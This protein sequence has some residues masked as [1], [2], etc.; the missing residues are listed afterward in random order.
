MNLLDVAQQTFVLLPATWTVEQARVFM[1][2]LEFSHVI[3]QRDEPE[4]LFYLFD[5]GRAMRVLKSA[6]A[7]Q[8]LVVAFDL[9]ES[10][11][12]PAL[13]GQLDRRAV[14]D[15]AVVLDEGRPAGFV[16]RTNPDVSFGVDDG[17]P[18][19]KGL[20]D[21]FSA[22]PALSAPER[23]ASEIPFDVFVG[24]RSDPDP[25][26]SSSGPLVFENVQP[27]EE[28][29]VVL[30]PDGATLD[31]TFD[32]LPLRMNANMRF[33]CTPKPGATSITL[34]AQFFY[35]SQFAGSATRQ[36]AVGAPATPAPPQP[37]TSATLVRPQPAAPANPCRMTLPNEQQYVDLTVT[38]SKTGDNGLHWTF[39]AAQPPIATKQPIHTELADAREFAAA[40]IRELQTENHTGPGASNILE[41]Q[42]QRIA[43][44]MP[45]EFF[46]ALRDVHAAIERTPTL[47][48]LT[49]EMY[50]P[51]EL[52]LLDEPL[53]PNAP[54][55][56][57]AQTLM[58]RWLLNDQVVSPPAVSVGVGRF[59]V[60]AA[61]YGLMA[62]LPEL[63][64]ALA[65]QG[66]LQQHWQAITLD[67]TKADIQ[68][69]S[70]ARVPGHLIHFAVHGLSNPAA[71][72][73]ALL[74]A[75]RTRLVPSAIVGRYRC[76][77]VPRFSFVF[78]NACQVGSAGS[79]LGQV[80]GFPGELIRGGALGFIAPLWEV[81]DV[82]AR[83]LA[84]AFYDATLAHEQTV[85]AVLNAQRR[86]YDGQGSTTPIAYIYYGHPAL[87]LRRAQ[88]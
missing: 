35:R 24:F 37:A 51:W 69:A 87:R 20:D 39:A 9:H 72:E 32:Q 65:E 8:P 26:L 31:R 7:D 73:Q 55:Y 29:L 44:H 11:A 77:E 76:G 75:D 64:E 66:A 36:V 67:A 63:K 83:H 45:A 13:D 52:A 17:Q 14:P 43:E 34:T 19:P 61:K 58:G 10:S 2:D 6:P 54:P 33:V 21:R 25:D 41:V 68:A 62:G 23:V 22:F 81:H 71:N 85:G 15:R 80:A 70:S 82:V 49:D 27:G 84:E 46:Q 18:I 56:L 5:A 60:V 47:L 42:G 78:L 1:E 74:L 3:V 50:V 88:V 16:D 38:I 57:A 53:D 4:E 28:C 12:T 79:S 86:G 48:L 59:T 30:I 40:L